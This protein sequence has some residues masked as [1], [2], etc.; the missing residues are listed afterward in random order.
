MST[1]SD[2]KIPGFYSNKIN[3]STAPTGTNVIHDSLNGLDEVGRVTVVLGGDTVGSI[4]IARVVGLGPS[5]RGSP[6]AFLFEV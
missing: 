1:I 6:G 5:S 3:H 4:L 2:A